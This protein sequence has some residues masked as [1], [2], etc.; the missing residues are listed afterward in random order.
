MSIV[1]LSLAEIF[2]D[3]GFK[4]VARQ[5]GLTNWA[6]GITGYQNEAAFFY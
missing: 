5:G 2:G 1:L 4:G 3:F 6:A